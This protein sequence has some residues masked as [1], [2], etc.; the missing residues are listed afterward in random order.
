M[1]GIRCLA[2]G[3]GRCVSGSAMRW[4]SLLLPTPAR[5]FGSRVVDVVGGRYGEGEGEDVS[6]AINVRR[7]RRRPGFGGG[8]GG[9]GGGGRGVGPPRGPTAVC[10]DPGLI[11]HW[12]LRT[13]DRPW[14]PSLTPRVY[15]ARRHRHHRRRGRRRRNDDD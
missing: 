12:P 13:F 15:Y 10:S 6:S 14:R 11:D 2:G 4:S 3:V 8:G 5:G 1:Q 9:G 7:R